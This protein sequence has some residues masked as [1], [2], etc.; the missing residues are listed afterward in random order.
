MPIGEGLEVY[1]PSTALVGKGIHELDQLWQF[2]LLYIAAQIVAMAPGSY[3]PLERP[4]GLNLQAIKST[5]TPRR[6]RNADG[7]VDVMVGVNHPRVPAVVATPNGSVALVGVALLHPK[8]SAYIQAGDSDAS[9]EVARKL[10]QL[11]PELLN[12]PRRKP[13]VSG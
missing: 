5:K 3:R 7:T 6:W 2:E 10:E 8:E 9:S 12:N 4:G 13:V 11:P 1:V